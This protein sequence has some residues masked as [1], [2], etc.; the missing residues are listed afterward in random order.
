MKKSRLYLVLSLFVLCLNLK[1]QE[2]NANQAAAGELYYEWVSDST[3]RFF[4][5][6]YRDCSGSAE[7]ATMP[8][9]FYNTCI[10]TGFSTTMVKFSTTG[11]STTFSCTQYKSKCDSPASTIPGVKEWLYYAVVTM[12]LRCNAWKIYTYTGPRNASLNLLNPTS[13][14]FCAE[15]MMN[16]TNGMHGNSSPY[17]TLKPWAYVCINSPF[18]YNV[19][20]IDP[21]GDSVA[22]EIINCKTGVTTCSDTPG[23]IAFA[24]G[25][26]AYSL[27]TNP[28]QTGNTFSL[29]AAASQMGFTPT[30]LGTY[31]LAMKIKEYRNNVLIGWSTRD[32]QF[33]ILPC[34]TPTSS[35]TVDLSSLSGCT[36]TAGKIYMC[37]GVPLS[38]C[39]YVKSTDTNALYSLMDNTSLSMP[40]AV[41]TY[42]SQLND[43]I[44][45]CVTWT[46]GIN[47]TGGRSFVVTVK[48]T[49][50]GPPWAVTLKPFLTSIYL[51]PPT[52]TSNDTSIC[53][54]ASAGLKVSGAGGYTW[55]VLSGTPGSLSCTTCINPT[56]TPLVT[57]K[58]IATSANNPCGNNKDTVTVTVL[59]LTHPSINISVNPGTSI[60]QGSTVKFYPAV[61]NCSSPFYR[62]Y[63]NG[64]PYAVI[65]T[66]V[67]NSLADLDNISCKLTCNDIC[68]TPKDTMS[69]TI[70]MHVVSVEEITNDKTIR[71]YPN[72]NNG[73]FILETAA[74]L[75][76]ALHIYNIQGQEVLKYDITKERTD[77]R[78]PQSL[79]AGIYF[80]RFVSGD[81]ETVVLKIIC[82]K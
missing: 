59:P 30:Q 6:Y 65:D 76:G 23:S 82:N 68:A 73:E 43:S 31:T 7:P 20:A 74:H 48:D 26:P 51:Y 64:N 10:S 16:N 24:T 35:M 3:Y 11:I 4:F 36:Y 57:S 66:L 19:G 34:T 54:N 61:T 75:S 63:R 18:T 29:N 41:V 22:A 70:T 12:P 80:G 79:N 5:K 28:I 32:V 81:K 78:F 55:S 77:V 46:P 42:S 13:M 44:R 49:T 71:I 33:N 60:S 53:L 47:D 2:V 9:C 21:N 38:F 8:L 58:Y 45:G 40:G 17:N 62:W 50:C 1:P 56:A 15:L 69:N 27:T 37:A 14:A 52:R 39:F 72:P 67:I 25:F